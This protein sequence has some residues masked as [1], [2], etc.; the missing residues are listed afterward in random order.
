MYCIICL[1]TANALWEQTQRCSILLPAKSY[2]N[3]S[4]FFL[5]ALQCLWCL[6]QC[7]W[8]FKDNIPKSTKFLIFVFLFCLSSEKF[9]AHCL[10][11]QELWFPTV[12][13]FFVKEAATR[14][15]EIK[16]VLSR[17]TILLIK[18]TNGEKQCKCMSVIAA[19]MYVEDVIGSWWCNHWPNFVKYIYFSK[20]HITKCTDKRKHFT[21]RKSCVPVITVN[22]V[23]NLML[24][25]LITALFRG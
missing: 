6:F 17:W 4:E 8:C 7:L 22:F 12:G 21:M 23:L 9:V 16:F 15:A 1:V 2:A 3:I 14:V 25:V 18:R 10:S 13:F 20:R 24:W 11:F 5:A 19:H